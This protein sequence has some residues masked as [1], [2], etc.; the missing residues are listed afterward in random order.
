MTFRNAEKERPSVPLF[1]YILTSDNF[2]IAFILFYKSKAS[3][4]KSVAQLLDRNG[5]L[6]N[7]IYILNKFNLFK[8]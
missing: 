5:H 4:Y 3:N 6:E 7:S 8:I 2:S 1:C